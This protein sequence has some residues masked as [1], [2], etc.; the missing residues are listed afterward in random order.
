[1]NYKFKLDQFEGPL[2][3]LLDMIE[4]RKLSISSVSLAKI[5]DEYIKH[6]RKLEEFPKEEV[7]EFLVV[8]ST[9]MLIKSRSLLPGI[10]LSEEEEKDIYDL[11]FRLNLLKKIRELSPHI[12][13]AWA[14]N[15]AFSREAFFAM[16]LGFIEPKGVDANFL[17][18]SLAS[19]IAAFPKIEMLPEKTIQKIISIEEK[20]LELVSR[21]SAKLKAGFHEIV[22]SK[23]K[24]DVIVG[25]LALLELVK[26]GAFLVKQDERF[27]NIEIEK[28]DK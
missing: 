3:L 7:A 23:N 25:F 19:I 5:T 27:G 1:M 18:E 26:Q 16:D 22:A 13:K 20:M 9:L 2:N 24:T 6:I 17:K 14:K 4:S 11:E 15:P 10:E 8:A 21:F 28:K 12:K